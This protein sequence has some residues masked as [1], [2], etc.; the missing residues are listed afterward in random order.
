VLVID[1]LILSDVNMAVRKAAYY[2]L[3]SS[4]LV[5]DVIGR[6]NQD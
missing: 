5:I 6:A 3:M 4:P 1:A 2:S